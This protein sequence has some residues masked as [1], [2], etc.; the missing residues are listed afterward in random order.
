MSETEKTNFT[1][2]RL[3]QDILRRSSVGVLFTGRSASTAVRGASNQAYGVDASFAFYENVDLNGYYART[4]TPGL[5]GRQESYRSRFDYAADRYGLLVDHFFVG[6]DFNP[7]VGFVRRDDMRRTFVQGRFS[8][9]SI[10]SVRRFSWQ[11]RLEYI[12]NTAGQLETREQTATFNT[13]FQNSDRFNL[14]TSRTYELLA[15]PLRLADGIAVRPGGYSFDNVVAQYTFGQQRRMSGALSVGHGNFYDGRQTSFGLTS[16]RVEI[17][18]QFSLEPSLSINWIDLPHATLTTRL[19]RSRVSYTFTPRMFLSGLLQ[20]NSSSD[21]IS[22]NFRLRWEYSP[23]SELFVVYT[24]DRN[25]E[26]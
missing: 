13:E 9:R 21:T 12:E 23:G 10:R 19:F 25:T 22:T 3:R 17:T 18:P 14:E 1:V 4:E 20:Y 7:E 8:P 11:G 15:R 24:E 26:G 2:L 16:G 5:T 6:D